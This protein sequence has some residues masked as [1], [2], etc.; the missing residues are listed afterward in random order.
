VPLREDLLNP[1]A[2][3][4]PAG[5]SLRYD[6]VYDQI[7]D[8]RTEEDDSLPSGGWSRQTKKADFRA[9]AKLAGDALATR[10]KDLQ[11]AVWLGEALIKLEGAAMF[12]PVL[13]LFLDLQQT[14]WDT[15][16]P[17]I[18]EGDA[19]MRAAPLQWAATRYTKLLNE[20]GL[21]RKGVGILEYKAARAL[22]TEEEASRNDAKRKARE[23]A[24][25]AGKLTSEEVTDAITATP[26][27]F[28][29]ALENQVTDALNVLNELDTFC[30]EKYRDD[31]PSYRTLRA[32]LEEVQNLV[33]SLL[34]EK[35]KLDP[36]PVVAPVIEEP[37]IEE[38]LIESLQYSEPAPAAVPQP[39]F[40]PQPTA[41]EEVAA[42]RPAAA[43]AR[44]KPGGQSATPESWEDALARI[45]GAVGYLTAQ[46]PES[47]LPFLLSSAV[48]MAELYQLVVDS[49]LD[50]IPAPPSEL[51]QRLKRAA[52]DR[53]WSEVHTAA[54][55]ALASP[56]G[57]GWLDL[58]R[59]LWV[60]CDELGWYTQRNAVASA[61]KQRLRDLPQLPSLT[62]NDDTPTANAET[63]RWI[64]EEIEPAPPEPAPVEPEIEEEVTAAPPPALQ[65]MLAQERETDE[66]PE[67]EDLFATAR[68]LAAHGQIQ[69]A[70]Q[71]LA[72]DAAHQPVGRL[73]FNRNLQIAELC[74]ESGN[75]AVAVPVLQGL[76][77]EVEERRLESWEPPGSAAKP[78]ALL[79]QCANVAKLDTQSIFA[80]LCAIDPS[81]ALS[82]A[83]P[84]ES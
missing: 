84:I 41:A 49:R 79:L 43:A 74:L 45:A 9:A 26:K 2:G 47:T 25:A 33:G 51:R 40:E 60:S 70:I 18:D 7:K 73:R 57:S 64:Q 67:M 17:E 21:T 78:Y 13:Q 69:G 37:I 53:E 46:K 80:R 6:R 3:A 59:Y 14:F 24:V 11:L 83:P 30:E 55:A 1:I 31:S 42:V 77:R 12:A 71:L 63:L 66:S 61:V 16:H 56:C 8:A 75:S 23:E 54:I 19:G 36:D 76:V 82:M 44:P 28:Y 10:S 48:R 4:N 72:R 39:S 34:R 68:G 65:S 32:A 62:L 38:E 52:S 27:S 58:Y 81:A 50:S 20:V 35:R 5:P 15:L 29:V 22:G